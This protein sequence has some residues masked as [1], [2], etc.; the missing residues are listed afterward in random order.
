VH[1]SPLPS[2]PRYL[3]R[4]TA[5]CFWCSGL[6]PGAA[7]HQLLARRGAMSGSVGSWQVSLRLRLRFGPHFTPLCFSIL[8]QFE[9]E[10]SAR[11]ICPFCV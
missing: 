2:D 4:R 5:R 11:R 6:V 7:R 9:K 10:L 8:D 1:Y 3:I